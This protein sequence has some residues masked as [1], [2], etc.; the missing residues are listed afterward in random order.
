MKKT[1]SIKLDINIAK[2]I[3]MI[4]NLEQRSFSNMVQKILTDYLHGDK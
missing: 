3:E 1:V 2:Q 4:A